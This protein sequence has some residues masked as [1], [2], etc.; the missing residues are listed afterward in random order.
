[1]KYRGI[2]IP[3][4]IIQY[5]NG[6]EPFSVVVVW[7]MV[8][9]MQKIKGHCFASNGYFVKR[10]RFNERTI[11]NALRILEDKGILKRTLLDGKRILKAKVP[12]GAV[13]KDFEGKTIIEGVKKIH[14][15]MKKIHP[16]IIEGVKKIHPKGEKDSPP[17][18]ENTPMDKGQ[19]GGFGGPIVK[20]IEKN[21]NV[22]TS[23]DDPACAGSVIKST[24]YFINLIEQRRKVKISHEKKLEWDV[25][26]RRLIK[27]KKVS[28]VKFKGILEWY[29]FNM[30]NKY[31]PRINSGK[32]LFDKWEQLNNAYARAK[33]KPIPYPDIVKI[34]PS[35][36]S[37]IPPG[38]HMDLLKTPE[39]L[40]QA[41]LKTP[42]NKLQENIIRGMEYYCNISFPAGNLYV[43]VEKCIGELTQVMKEIKCWAAYWKD[44]GTEDPRKAVTAE[45][46][47]ADMVMTSANFGETY[48]QFLRDQNWLKTF[49]VE[50]IRPGGHLFNKFYNGYFEKKGIQKP[51]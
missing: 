48:G 41:R 22:Y 42:D 16:E 35:P 31:T 4:E 23:K 36:V 11:Q 37:I 25:F 46:L 49:T 44:R 9:S 19:S 32:D 20:Y 34:K 39:G 15:P 1:M 40:I 27:E 29:K 51:C 26:I 21:K 13:I 10:T 30:G 50:A 43:P 2:W 8:V 3:D 38:K 5:C 14:P 17:P 6:N 7:S 47:F 45:W 33:N 28:S 12:K 18:P 24:E